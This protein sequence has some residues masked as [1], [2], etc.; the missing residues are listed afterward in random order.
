MRHVGRHSGNPLALQRRI[1]YA[2]HMEPAS[3][4]DFP[5]FI[6][7]TDY[8]L[9]DLRAELD[10]HLRSLGYHPILSSSEGFHDSTPSLEPWESCLPT[11][12]SC[13]VVVLVIDGRYGQ[14]L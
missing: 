3:E 12:E 10:Q 1:T 4:L 6:S 5:I 7:S 9:M 2:P 8:N 14:P 13:F 11:L